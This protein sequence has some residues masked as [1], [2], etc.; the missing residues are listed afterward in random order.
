MKR[1][2]RSNG[3]ED[4]VVLVRYIHVWMLQSFLICAILACMAKAKPTLRRHQ[5]ERTELTCRRLLEAAEEVFIHDGFQAAK[6]E[7]IAQAAGYTRGAFYANF[8]S[9]EDLFMT[10]AERQLNGLTDKLRAAVLSAS[11]VEKKSEA[12]LK[13][14][15]ESSAARRWALLL[16]EFNLFVLRQ[17]QLKRRAL[18]MLA[19]LLDGIA[20]VFGDLYT[21][22][23]R[24]P[25]VSITV[26]GLGFGAMFQ[27]LALQKILNRKLLS[28]A[29]ITEVLK[30]YIEAMLSAGET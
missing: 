2:L 5:K 24:K 10:V 27:G 17:P 11:G 9:K 3:H 4:L 18:P 28:S 16:L 29:E 1:I 19:R 23:N 25:P 7:D 14:V 30:R 12:V 22:A 13:I 15:Q 21:A 8:E 20:T 26:I 6:L